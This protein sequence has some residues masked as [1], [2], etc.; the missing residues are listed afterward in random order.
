MSQFLLQLHRPA[1]QEEGRLVWA[2]V[3]EAHGPDSD[4]GVRGS[5]AGVHT[6]HVA[7]PGEADPLPA[8]AAKRAGEDASVSGPCRHVGDRMDPGSW[9]QLGVAWLALAPFQERTRS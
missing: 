6:G 1:T 8:N 4:S 7:S 9:L 3:T 2:S 5:R